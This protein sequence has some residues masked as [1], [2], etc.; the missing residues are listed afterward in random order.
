MPSG[1]KENEEGF[2]FNVKE[3]PN[4]LC[5]KVVDIEHITEGGI[6]GGHINFLVLE[7]GQ[8]IEVSDFALIKIKINHTYRIT[9]ILSKHPKIEEIRNISECQKYRE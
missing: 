8:R 7:E 5:G 9:G 2:N 4:T 6:F 1:G 3:Y